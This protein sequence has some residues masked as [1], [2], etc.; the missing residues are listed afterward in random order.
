M[1]HRSSGYYRRKKSNKWVY[2]ISLSLVIIAVVAFVRRSQEQTDTQNVM[3][4]DR[5]AKLEVADMGIPPKASPPKAGPPINK[6]PIKVVEKKVIPEVELPKIVIEQIAEPNSKASILINDAIKLVNGDPTKVID[7]RDSLNEIL[8]KVSLTTDQRDFV[9]K[10][11]SELSDKWLFNRTIYPQDSLC[12]SYRVQ[13][14]DL[15]SNIGHRYSIPYEILMEINNISRPENLQAGA[16]IKIVYGPFHARIYKSTFTM[17]IYLQNMFIKSL[18]IGL[19][20]PGHETP[21]GTWIVKSGGKLVKPTWTDPDTGKL[22]ESYDPDYPLGSRWVGLEGI[23]GAAVGRDGFAIHGTKDPSEIGGA[24]S[25]GCIRLHNG[26]AIMV[27]NILAE[28]L[29]QVV[30]VD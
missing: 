7:A 18:P 2:I 14:G 10:Q 20:K 24:T 16:P 8:H 30:V 29:S 17:D 13:S 19:G 12:G 3:A 21:T 5:I 25:R 27:Y 15:L 23:E 4:D 22:Y 28:G 1:A 26:S 6:P 11:L 9:K